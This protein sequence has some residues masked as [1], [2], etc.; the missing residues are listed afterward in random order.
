[1]RAAQ[2]PHLLKFKKNKILK[3]APSSSNLFAIPFSFCNQKI[4]SKKYSR[5]ETFFGYLF[6]AL[7]CKFQCIFE[8][9]N[10][11]YTILLSKLLH[12]YEWNAVQLVSIN[13]SGERVYRMTLLGKI[14]Y[15]IFPFFPLRKTQL[16]NLALPKFKFLVLTH[17]QCPPYPEMGNKREKM[18]SKM[19]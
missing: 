19:Q 9:F 5:P 10:V 17:G 2:F 12:I 3:Y 18:A 13:V 14:Y 6:A 11:F 16:Y 1:M 4:L 15:L 7:Q 8:Y